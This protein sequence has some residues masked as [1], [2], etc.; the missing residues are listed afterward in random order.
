MGQFRISFL[1]RGN[2]QMKLT[3]IVGLVEAVPQCTRCT[4]SFGHRGYVKDTVYSMPIPDMNTWKTQVQDAILA[5]TGEI[6]AN[7]L[8]ETK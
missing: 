7:T 4:F 5:I 3:L 8:A 2:F 6:V 1:I